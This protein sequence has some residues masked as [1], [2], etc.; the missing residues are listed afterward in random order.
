MRITRTACI[1]ARTKHM[2]MFTN[3]FEDMILIYE[4][5]TV[6]VVVAVVVLV[7]VVVAVVVDVAAVV[8]SSSTSGWKRRVDLILL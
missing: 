2:S 7:V 6:V 3:L 1:S 5:L 4:R 8:F